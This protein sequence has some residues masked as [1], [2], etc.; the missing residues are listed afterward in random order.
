M[1]DKTDEQV[2]DKTDEQV[3]DTMDEH[4][5]DTMDEKMNNVL[6][7]ER[8][9]L[10]KD[11]IVALVCLEDEIHRIKMAIALI[12]SGKIIAVYNGDRGKPYDSNQFSLMTKREFD[13]DQNKHSQN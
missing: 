3:I 2:I 4:V 5:I 13:E 8:K 11:S 10:S 1:D 6:I 12:K 7:D 9:R